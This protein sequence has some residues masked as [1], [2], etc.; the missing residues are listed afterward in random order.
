MGSELDVHPDA[1]QLLLLMRKAGVCNPDHP[2]SFSPKFCRRDDPRK[3]VFVDI[4]AVWVSA[5]V[6]QD[7]AKFPLK[8]LTLR[9]ITWASN[10][11]PRW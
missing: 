8:S 9:L 1:L 7:V 5:V 2:I 6:V 10:W 11:W 3:D 4:P